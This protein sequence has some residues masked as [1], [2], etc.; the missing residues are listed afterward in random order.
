MSNIDK[1]YFIDR[2]KVEN[3]NS[4]DKKWNYATIS[5]YFKLFGTY[6]FNIL[7]KN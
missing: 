4:V 1:N 6:Y 7:I 2:K 5:H 3:Y